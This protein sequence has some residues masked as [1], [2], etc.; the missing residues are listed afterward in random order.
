MSETIDEYW[1]RYALQLA[2]RARE[3]GE[4]P[5]GAVLVQGDKAIGEG[6]NRPIGQ[7]DPT[8][9]AEMMALREGGKVLDT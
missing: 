2:R 7:H 9:H 1:M 3:Q 5:V 8:A 4:V 6:W